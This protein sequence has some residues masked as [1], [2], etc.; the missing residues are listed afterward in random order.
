MR[1]LAVLAMMTL[2]VHGATL[3][4]LLAAAEKLRSWKG[5]EATEPQADFKRRL[6][7]WI[8]SRLPLGITGEQLMAELKEAG[9]AAEKAFDWPLGSV[10]A[11][12]FSR[13]AN[14]PTAIAVKTGVGEGCGSDESWYMYV[15]AADGWKRI[16]EYE[17]DTP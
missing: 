5:H 14:Y 17:P 10:T 9:L 12:D 4:D 2:S 13:P 11:I 3:D 8:E 7:D 1:V 6:R 15:L 16:L